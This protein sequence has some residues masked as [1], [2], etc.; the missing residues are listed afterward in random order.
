ML[1]DERSTKC[2]MKCTGPLWITS[3]F[4]FIYGP[5]S[6]GTSLNFRMLP[7]LYLSWPLFFSVLLYAPLLQLPCVCDLYGCDRSRAVIP[8]ANGKKQ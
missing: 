7:F 1:A 3:A 5:V 8:G 4:R 2:L 6:R